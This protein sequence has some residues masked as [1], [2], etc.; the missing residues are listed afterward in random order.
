MAAYVYWFL[1]AVLL[2]GLEMATGTFYLLML[3]VAMMVGGVAA[4]LGAPLTAQFALTAVAM[5]AGI[6]WLRRWKGSRAPAM[7]D[8]S[9]D[10]GQPVKVLSWQG[11]N[12]AR[13]FYRGA[14][15]DAELDEAGVSR[16]S[17]LYIKALHGSTVILTPHKPQT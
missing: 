2:I 5:V 15:W 14:E 16:E 9:L 13:V 8:A 6:V 1:L 7:V 17:T 10:I 4:L 11:D 12:R 3:G